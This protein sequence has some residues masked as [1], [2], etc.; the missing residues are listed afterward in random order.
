VP[1]QNGTLDVAFCEACL[2]RIKISKRLFLPGVALLLPGLFILSILL[3]M[4]HPQS[5]QWENFVRCRG[6][7]S[8]FLCFEIHRKG[9]S[10]ATKNSHCAMAV[11]NKFFEMKI[12]A[13]QQVFH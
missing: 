1:I 11:F 2:L 10:R 4:P 13:L 6:T 7:P 8:A 5:A 12:P 9:H 3:S